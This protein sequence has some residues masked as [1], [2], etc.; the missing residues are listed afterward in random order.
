MYCPASCCCCCCR[1]AP[2]IG[3]DDNPN[4]PADAKRLKRE[5]PSTW[6]TSRTR[7]YP[8]ETHFIKHVTPTHCTWMAYDRDKHAI[9]ALTGGTWSLKDG[10]YEETIEFAIG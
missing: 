7:I 8:K 5:L 10:K 2:C 3:G 1:P 9:L 6:E 4:A